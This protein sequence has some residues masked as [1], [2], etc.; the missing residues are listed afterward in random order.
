MFVGHV[1]KIPVA[2]DA[3]CNQS[4]S[5]AFRKKVSVEVFLLSGPEE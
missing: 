1:L 3:A 5:V 4:V 2:G